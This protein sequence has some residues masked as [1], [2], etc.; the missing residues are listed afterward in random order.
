[1]VGCPIGEKVLARFIIDNMIQALVYLIQRFFYRIIEF[2]RH[3]Y[4]KSFRY[5]SNFC[6]NVFERLDRFFAWK[7]TFRNI[8]KPLYGD[9][10]LIGYILGFVFRSIRFTLASLIYLFL[11]G[12]SVVAYL[13]WV[14][15]PVVLVLK[16]FA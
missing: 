10:S 5:Y 3:W 11:F 1:L 6:L 7:I 9:Y 4:I 12:V 14:F 15:L 8:L 13:M 2:L 16:A